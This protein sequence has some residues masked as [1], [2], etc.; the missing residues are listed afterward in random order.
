MTLNG[1]TFLSW[2]SGKDASL[3][4]SVLKKEGLHIPELLVTT[5]TAKL[6][7]VT[8][9][10]LRKELLLKQAASLEIPLMEI[11]LEESS[12][13]ENYEE[14]MRKAYT[15]L[16]EQG[17]RHGA[18]GDIFL[19]DLK[20]YR[21]KQMEAFGLNGI[22]PL[23]EKDTHSLLKQFIKEGFKAVVISAKDELLNESFVGREVDQ[24]FLEDLPADV[25][26]CGENGEFHTFC[27]D[28]PIFSQ[29][30]AF[31]L[32][33]KTLR[34]YDNPEGEGR[35]GFWFCDLIPS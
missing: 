12:S 11:Q 32:G 9:H 23:W 3:A 30:I 7:R 21:D 28:G 2:S 26:S 20:D 31:H 10:G 25:D 14:A 5:V 17:Y 19:E 16:H 27:Y 29:P 35:V 22:Y 1:R 34:Y 6:D 24:S 4:L 15:H 8:M 33:E 13:M 18:Y